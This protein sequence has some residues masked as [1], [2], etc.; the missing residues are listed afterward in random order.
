MSE[1]M[2]RER[3]G[4]YLGNDVQIVPHFTNL[5]KEKIR[6]GYESSGADISIIEV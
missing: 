3:K 5:V 2:T 6:L 4:E 1:I